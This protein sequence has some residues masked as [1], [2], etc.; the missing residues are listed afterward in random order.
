[1]DTQAKEKITRFLDDKI[2]SKAVYDTLL[3]AFLTPP[4]PTSSVYEL[5]A[6][7]IAINLLN[8]AWKKLERVKNTKDAEHDKPGQIGL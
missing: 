5:A 7:R 2:M 8:D 6:A 1:M 3:D 4:A